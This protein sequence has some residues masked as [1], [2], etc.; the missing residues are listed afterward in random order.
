MKLEE[1]EDLTYQLYTYGIGD[2]LQPGED[3]TKAIE[4]GKAVGKL[5]AV[6]R[7]AKVA[8]C[9]IGCKFDHPDCPTC[10]LMQTLEELEAT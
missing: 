8:M 10:I 3:C 4:Y 7:A 9:Q 6:A 5:L 1:L 2:W